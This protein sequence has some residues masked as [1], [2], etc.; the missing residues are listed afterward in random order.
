MKISIAKRYLLMVVVLVLIAAFFWVDA[1]QRLLKARRFKTPNLAE[2][3]ATESGD[4]DTWTVLFER[5]VPPKEEFALI[6]EKNV[7]SPLR[8]AWT[9][10]PPPV[11]ETETEPE[12]ELTPEETLP[13]RDD[14]ELRGTAMVGEERKAI[15]K[16]KSFRSGATLLLTE[17]A[18][19]QDKE[20]KDGP[21]FTVLHIK[22]ESVRLKDGAGKEFLVGLYDHD[23]ETPHTPVTQ[24]TMEVEPV[25]TAQAAPAVDSSASSAVVVG[26]TS[27]NNQQSAET[28]IQQ[29][30][31]K[32][33]Q[34]V[35]EGKM[36]KISTPFGPVYRKNE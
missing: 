20:A 24:T 5:R 29:Q 13:K 16:F 32:N 36:K 33:E 8:K 1:G 4:I 6:E 35:K 21:K 30:R 15:L 26:G 28:R 7:F 18:V 34:L 14:I 17:G 9:A 25:P 31:E 10:P 19:A 11:L 23:R 22:A 3:A 27:T 2:V 12:E